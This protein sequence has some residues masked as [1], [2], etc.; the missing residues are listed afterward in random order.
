MSIITGPQPNQA[1][2]TNTTNYW[3]PQETNLLNLHKAMEYN[4]L[5]QPVIRTTSGAAPTAN[6]AF[7]RLR[8]SNPLTLFDSF[9]R[10]NDNSKF[11]NYTTGTA[12]ITSSNVSAMTSMTIGTTSGDAAY[13]ESSRVF[14]YQPGKSLQVMTTFTMAETKENLRQRVGYFDT[15]N[16][17][18]LEQTGSTVTLNIRSSVSGGLLYETVSQSDWNGD[19]LNGSGISTLVLDLTKAQIFWIDIEW[20]GV[21]SVR[22]GFVIDGQFVTAH[23]FNHANR[24]ATTYMTTACLPVRYEIEN[25]GST[26]S[27]STLN[28]ICATVISEGGYELI[29]RPTSVGHTLA[30]PY[31]LANPNT[32]YPILSVRLKSSRLGAIVLPKNYSLGL[33][34]NNN[35]RFMLIVGGTTAGGTWSDAGVNSSVEYN[36]TGTSTSGGY[37]A[38]WRQ[39]IGSNQFAGAGDI[40]QPFK[41]QLER[42]TFT[43]TS[44]EITIALTTSG[45][46][47]N[48]YAAINWE[49]LT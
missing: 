45:N 46:N 42:N 44:S 37:I 15:S 36:L 13:R 5:G 30:V 8:V 24:I 34:G 9:Y 19:P 23:Q 35:F 14:A 2:R 26:A 22:C 29:G 17:V 20:L 6:D 11:N 4:S 10:Y 16:G 12:S 18:Y 33:T 47:V 7:G 41:Y 32:V 1:P 31:S 38:E 28:Q 21:G 25:V 43:G 40:A 39:I 27:S 3:H 48:V 49:E